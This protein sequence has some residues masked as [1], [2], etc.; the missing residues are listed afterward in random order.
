[1]NVC[2]Y[3]GHELAQLL[4]NTV[5]FSQKKFQ[6]KTTIWSNDC[7]THSNKIQ[8]YFQQCLYSQGPYNIYNVQKVE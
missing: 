2:S 8:S 6:N 3:R 1:M 5:Q 7:V 4:R